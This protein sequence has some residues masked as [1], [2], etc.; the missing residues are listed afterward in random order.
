VIPNKTN[1][2]WRK[3]ATGEKKIQTTQLGLQ[4]LLKRISSKVTPTAPEA[5]VAAAAGELHDFFV[6]YEK[7]LS[8]E[9]SALGS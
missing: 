3:L 6:K 2:C 4:M 7:I 8:A 9:I 1:A 5:E